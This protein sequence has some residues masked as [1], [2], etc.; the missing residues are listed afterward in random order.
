MAKQPED[1]LLDHA[2]DGIR[3]FNNHLPGWWLWLMYISIFASIVYIAHYHVLG[4]GDNQAVEYLR[5]VD[6]SYERLPEDQGVVLLAMLPSYNAPYSRTSQDVT[7]ALLY[8][9]FGGGEETIIVIEEVEPLTDPAS[10]AKGQALYVANC[11][12]CHGGGGEG[13]I[14]PNLTDPY[15]IHGGS[16]SQIAHT[17]KKGVP[18]KGMIAWEKSLKPDELLAVASYVETLYGTN[19]PNPKTPQGELVDKTTV[20]EK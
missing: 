3:E 5:E 4:T 2:Y 15:W 6:P 1:K 13:G 9:R 20:A 11:V 16:F 12:S 10:L 8:K 19:P 14:G 18:V 17:I 7:Q